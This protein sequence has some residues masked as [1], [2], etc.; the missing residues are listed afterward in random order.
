[1][2]IWKI[3]SWPGLWGKKSKRNKEKYIYEFALP[4]N[5]VTLGYGWIP[6]LKKLSKEEIRN[7]IIKRKLGTI[8][9]RTE[10]ISNFANKILKGDVILL[11]NCLQS[12][13]GIVTRKYYYVQQYSGKDFFGYE[14]PINRAPHR[15]DV[16]W[17]FNKK[18]FSVDFRCWQDTLYQIGHGDLNKIKDSFLKKFTE[19]CFY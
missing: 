11:Y 15:I 8:K 6:H 9:R 10:E 14:D 19:L 1:M 12:F 2:N 5:F 17:L 18:P 13:V 4:K 3:G 7:F 16:I